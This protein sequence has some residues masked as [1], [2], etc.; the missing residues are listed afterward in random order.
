M[1]YGVTEQMCVSSFWYDKAFPNPT[2][3]SMTMEEIAAVNQQILAAE[4]SKMY[5]LEAMESS[6]DASAVKE[7][8]LAAGIPDKALYVN[9]TPINKSEYFGAL[10]AAMQNTCY[11][12]IREQQYAVCTTRANLRRWP[13]DDILGYSTTDPDDEL[14]DSA[15]LVNEP[16]IVRQSCTVNGKTF[17]W[18]YT[19]TYSGWVNAE[20]FGLCATRQ[21]WLDAWKVDPEKADFLVVTQDKIITEPAVLTPNT[22]NV[23]LTLGTILKLIPSEQLSGNIGERYGWYNYAV[24]LP[25]RDANG[26]LVRQPCFI[27]QHEGVSIGFLPFTQKNLL[28]VAFTCLGDRYG[29]GGMLDS[30]DCSL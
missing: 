13:T 6:Y 26:K 30:L 5:D 22:S 23:R 28:D 3:G 25:T 15:V 11:T 20:C 17:Y 4:S 2:E 18:G 24:Y 21:E 12:G 1:P 16:F 9:G 14:Q 8:V 10:R 19:N 29:W 27:P 7:A